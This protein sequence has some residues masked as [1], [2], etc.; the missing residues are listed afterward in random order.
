[1]PVE[2]SIKTNAQDA[3]RRLEVSQFKLIQAERN[4]LRQIKELVL[5]NFKQATTTWRHKPYFQSYESTAGNVHTIRVSTDDKI[6][7]FV[8]KGTRPHMIF[9]KK[10]GGRLRFQWGGHGSYVSKTLPGYINSRAGGSS[11][12][13]VYRRGV[14]HPGTE[15]RHITETVQEIWQRKAPEVIERHIQ[16][17]LN[18][19]GPFGR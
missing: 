2:I 18:S 15:P 16:Q 12:P 14:K 5:Q 7:K 8:D 17:A 10:P 19:N 4:A 11:G 1:M 3:I 9:P 13:I 6:Y